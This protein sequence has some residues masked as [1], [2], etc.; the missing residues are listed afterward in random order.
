V[1]FYT[2]KGPCYNLEIHDTKI[3][4][5]K[6]GWW[7]LFSFGPHGLAWDTEQLSNF[8]ITS[9]KGLLWGKLEW[10][11]FAGQSE[12][13]R[14][15]TNMEMVQRIEKYLQKVTVRNCERQLPA[16]T[17]AELSEPVLSTAV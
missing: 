9:S 16:G 7:R 13:F 8:K 11:N 15:M 17:T 12:S 3:I 5:V 4:L 6:K 10:Q 14:F 2:L 1:I